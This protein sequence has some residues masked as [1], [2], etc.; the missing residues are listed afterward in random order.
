MCLHRLLQKFITGAE[1][2]DE[3]YFEKIHFATD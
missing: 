3:Q 1:I 2:H